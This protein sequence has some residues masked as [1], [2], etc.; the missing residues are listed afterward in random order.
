[1]VYYARPVA[2][3][4][5]AA[6]AALSPVALGCADAMGVHV[7]TISLVI[8]VGAWIAQFRRPQAGRPETVFFEDL[9]IP[10]VG[11]ISV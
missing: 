2:G 7:L 3:T 6:M 10:L 9:A 4:F 1:M 11:P 8:F 5:L